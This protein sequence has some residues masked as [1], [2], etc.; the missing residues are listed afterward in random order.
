MNNFRRRF[1]RLPSAP[2]WLRGLRTRFV[3]AFLLVAVISGT[4]TASVS[5]VTARQAVLENAQTRILDQ[6]I[7]GLDELATAIRY[8]MDRASLEAFVIR[9]EQ[10]LP[11][12]VTAVYGSLQVP[13]AGFAEP[14]P[15]ALRNAVESTSHAQWQR[16]DISG[17]PVLVSGTPVLGSD[18]AP[19]GLAVFVHSSL[20]LEEERV[21]ALAGSAAQM[22]AYCLLAAVFVALF[23]ARGVLRPVREL[24]RAV[25]RLAGG[26][27]R[28]RLTVRG[29][30][31]LAELSRT[32]NETVAELERNIAELQRMEENARRFV[33]D[34]SHELRTPL[35]SLTAV[36]D[37][38]D[39][40]FA[41]VAGDAATAARLVG[42]QTRR[43][44]ELV[45]NLIEISRFD[46]GHAV[47]R[48]EEVVDIGAVVRATVA[49]RGWADL[50]QADLPSGVIAAVDVC[51]VEVIAANL[52]GNALRHGAQ[53]VV[54]SVGTAADG[55]PT[56]G[57]T[58]SVSD[59][60][61]GLTA[62]A[63]THLFERFYKADAGRTRSEGSGLGL[64]IALENARLHGGT[65]DVVDPPGGGATF[66]LHLPR[67][68]PRLA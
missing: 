30:D 23:A 28:T 19:S 68:P 4:A 52:I 10:V 6:T 18:G 15:A 65:I 63:R 54:V 45:E 21:N 49:A 16:V 5:Y 36:T 20:V 64:A 25:R 26:D 53:P 47:L 33:A 7:T 44:A 29:S 14:I 66:V 50:V 27:L 51:R 55:N 34:V 41:G 56:G 40:E 2:P 59:R 12:P 46:S 32:F 58:V 11:G 38:L 48:V 22:L 35:A 13:P 61:P 9:A 37:T 39:E 43:L 17:L 31:E 67:R 42:T 3:V 57:V 62:Q 24:R 8:P 60:G 1:R